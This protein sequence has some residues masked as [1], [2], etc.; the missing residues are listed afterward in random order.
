M[1]MVFSGFS[2]QIF[3]TLFTHLR[4]LCW[5]WKGVWKCM[6]VGSKA[7]PW[8]AV[9]LQAVFCLR[10]HYQNLFGA[11]AVQHVEQHR[12]CVYC[13]L[14]TYAGNG[15]TPSLNNLMN[16]VSVGGKQLIRSSREPLSS[17]DGILHSKVSNI[18]PLLHDFLKIQRCSGFFPA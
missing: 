1:Q 10:G 12:A 4:H 15:A 11:L 17:C 9:M 13:K 3:K 6:F 16:H 2:A 14:F 18:R 5:K 7:F 8:R